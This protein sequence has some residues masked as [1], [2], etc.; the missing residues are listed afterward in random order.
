MRAWFGSGGLHA[1][2]GLGWGDWGLR[3]RAWGDV[4]RVL[5]A[6]LLV[7]GTGVADDG[8][9]SFDE[10]TTPVQVRTDAI[11][12]TDD[13][14]AAPGDASA[15]A[16]LKKLGARI[17]QDDQGNVVELN[18]LAKQDQ[19]CRKKAAQEERPAT[20][21]SV[22]SRSKRMTTEKRPSALPGA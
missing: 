11:G 20:K 5:L 4:M 6:V 22:N 18:R 3:V 17:K 15:V 1:G 7:A 10:G 19:R 13:P 12:S 21:K 16:A 8:P 9:S 14:S 2:A